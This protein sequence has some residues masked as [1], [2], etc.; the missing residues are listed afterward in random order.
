MLELIPATVIITN[1]IVM[2]ISADYGHPSLWDGF[3]IAFTAFFTLEF[4]AKIQI[5]GCKAYWFGPEWAWNWFD[6][7]LLLIALIDFMAT[8]ISAI[9]EPSG[10]GTDF[11]SFLLIK[12][13]RL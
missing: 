10:E 11:G 4:L 13:L 3:E 9:I 6:A 12:L 7:L 5:F 8:R 2:G 1:G